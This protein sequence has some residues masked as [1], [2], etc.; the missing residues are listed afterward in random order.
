MNRLLP[1]LAAA[2]LLFAAA[3]GGSADSPPTATLPPDTPTPGATATATTPSTPEP[4]ATATA[5]P[6]ET[7]VPLPRLEPTGFPLDPDTVTGLVVGDVGS[8]T[9]DW[10]GGPPVREVSAM[11]QPSDDP[12]AANA[13]GWN[14]RVHVEYEGLPAVDWYVPEGTPIYATMDGT[15]TLYMNTVTNAFDY[16]GVSREPYIG[17][18]DRDRAPISAFPGPGGGMGVFVRIENA[19]YRVDYGHM[20]IDETAANV[21]EG[22]WIA[23][24]SGETDWASLY[25]VPRSYLVADAIARWP[26]KAGD[27]IGFTG[28]AGYSEAPHLHYAITDATTGG[29][30]CPTAEVG[31]SNGGWLFR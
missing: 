7:P 28:D 24:Y 1:W 10:S 22:A 31:F 11:L 14:C 13:A 4:T 29:R 2:G 15:A 3:C 6:T 27:L 20:R 5:V 26:V 23:G 16:W 8:R 19:G 18:P 30:L 9:F 21:P 25:S 12:V 17:N